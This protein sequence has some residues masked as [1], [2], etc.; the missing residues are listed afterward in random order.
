MTG[1]NLKKKTKLWDTVIFEIDK[2]IMTVEM[3]DI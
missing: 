2:T 3:F 1:F